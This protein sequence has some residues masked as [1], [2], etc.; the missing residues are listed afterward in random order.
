MQRNH[1]T[2]A[3]GAA[4]RQRILD[5]AIVRFA[6]YGFR[7]TS[8]AQVA[9]DA[10]VTPPAVHAYFG[11]K[12][13]LFNAAVEQDVA[14]LLDVVRQRLADE[15]IPGVGLALVPALLAALDPHPL[16]RRI[17]SGHEPERTAELLQLPAVART[18]AQAVAAITAAQQ[19]GLV[20]ADL[21][22]VALTGAL[23][24][25]LLALMLGAV[26][27]GMIGDDERRA[28]IVALLAQGIRPR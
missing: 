24:T 9:R 27:I 18:R 6:D 15:P 14:S 5:C 8:V 7:Q 20:R 21:E 12:E 16:A 19:A 10:G 13:A 3:K 11:D 23:E 1:P 22:P 25:L 17:F 4:T 28:A 2:S 26:Q